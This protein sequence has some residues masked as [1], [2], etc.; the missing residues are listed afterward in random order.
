[1]RF[2]LVALAALLFAIQPARAETASE[3]INDAVADVMATLIAPDDEDAHAYE[4]DAVRARLT[5][6]V[7]WHLAPPD[8]YPPEE[9]VVRTGWITSQWRST[10]ILL[11]GGAERVSAAFFNMRGA[12]QADL[13]QA[14]VDYGILDSYDAEADAASA[15]AA[16]GG[17]DTLLWQRPAVTDAYHL[18]APGHRQAILNVTRLCT[19]REARVA[20]S[21]WSEIRV[22]LLSE[23]QAGINDDA[24][25]D[26]SAP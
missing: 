26:R 13:L 10:G 6:K 4:W 21:C 17:D 3:D 15:L 7:N 23:T 5:Y 8:R 18:T 19:S 14:L 20:Q 22:A 24:C 11:C 25:R 16:Q 9:G 12:R 2:A 1:M